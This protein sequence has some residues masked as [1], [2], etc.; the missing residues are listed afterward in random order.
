M[1]VSQ[2]ALYALF[3]MLVVFAVLIVLWGII[4]LLSMVIGLMEGRQQNRN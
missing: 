3:C 1:S 2:A 4:R